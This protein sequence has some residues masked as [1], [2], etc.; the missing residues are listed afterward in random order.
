MAIELKRSFLVAKAEQEKHHE[1][2]SLAVP[3]LR[4]FHQDRA[5]HVLNAAPHFKD[6]RV[7]NDLGHKF[8]EAMAEHIIVRPAL[9]NCSCEKI[10]LVRGEMPAAH[11]FLH[12]YAAANPGEMCVCV[13]EGS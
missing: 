9:T 12:P 10:K 6:I 3:Y 2:H 11:A 7:P 8:L 13:R 4:V 5:K 1:V